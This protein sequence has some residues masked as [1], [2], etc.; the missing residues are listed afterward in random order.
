MFDIKLN[1]T[2]KVIYVAGSHLTNPPFLMAHSS[3]ISRDIFR[4][5]MLI[6]ALN[7]LDNLAGALKITISIPR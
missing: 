1:V 5:S 6:S 3:V 2:S 4:I 7:D